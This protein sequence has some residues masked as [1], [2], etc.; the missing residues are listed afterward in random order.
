MIPKLG[1][2][3]EMEYAYPMQQVITW[4]HNAGFTAVSPLW[5]QDLSAIS[6]CA[7]ELGMTVQSLHAPPKGMALLWQPAQPDSAALQK[8]MMDSLSAC[9]KFQI[10]VLVVHGWQGMGYTFPHASLDFSFWDVFVQ[11]AQKLGVSIAFE[12]LEG[13]EY[14]AALMERY[15]NLPYIGFCWDAG[16]DRCY[17]HETDF[18]DSFG[19]RLIMTHINDNFG[20]RGNA[21]TSK[22]DLHLLPFDGNTNWDHQ[23]IRLKGAAMQDILNFELKTLSH[24][25]STYPQW[26]LEQFIMEAGHRARQIAEKYIQICKKAP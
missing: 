10:P 11:Q 26:S 16:H 14:L 1:F 15:R 20:V 25:I 21:Y 17:P 8:S 23:L 5:G 22:D 2:S 12:N 18:L 24:G 7:T 3:L 4:L 19:P 9:A 6:A 13:E